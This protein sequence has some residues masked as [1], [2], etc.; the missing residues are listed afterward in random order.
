MAGVMKKSESSW[1]MKLLTLTVVPKNLPLNR[2]LDELCVVGD[3]AWLVVTVS[4]RLAHVNVRVSVLEICFVNRTV[5][6]IQN[7]VVHVDL[8]TRPKKID[9]CN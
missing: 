6:A 9:Y 2:M 8:R 4:D 5:H 7:C 1:M 3:G